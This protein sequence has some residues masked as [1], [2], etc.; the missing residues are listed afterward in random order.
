MCVVSDVLY[1]MVWNQ[2]VASENTPG[3]FLHLHSNLGSSEPRVCDQMW[4]PLSEIA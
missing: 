3:C 2:W 4:E 1:Y